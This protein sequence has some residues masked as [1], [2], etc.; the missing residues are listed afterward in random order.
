VVFISV[1]L[2]CVPHRAALTAQWS[3]GVEAGV[4][5]SVEFDALR[6]LP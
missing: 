6:R 1:F 2:E 4:E 5:T 3:A